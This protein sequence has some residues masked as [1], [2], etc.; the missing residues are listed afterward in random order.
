MHRP[1][2]IRFFFL[3]SIALAIAAGLLWFVLEGPESAIPAAFATWIA[4]LPVPYMLACLFSDRAARKAL[5]DA[6]ASSEGDALDLLKDVDIVLLRRRMLL[7]G[8]PHIKELAPEGMT[9]SALLALA[10]SAEQESDHPYARVICST[11]ENRLLRLHRLAARTA[12][13][14]A[15][16]EALLTRQALRVG[17]LDWLEEEGAKLSA[18]LST[19]ADQLSTKGLAVIGVGLGNRVRG[20]IAFEQDFSEDAKTTIAA[21]SH[22]NVKTVLCTS[23]SRRYG[24]AL[25]KAL[26]ITDVKAGATPEDLAR[27]LQLLKARGSVIATL[28]EDF[29]SI[30]DLTIT[31]APQGVFPPAASSADENAQ[32]PAEPARL[33]L[34]SL[35]PIPTLIA[36]TQRATRALRLGFRLSLFF[37][38]V[39]VLPAFGV[40]HA[41]GGPFFNP[42]IALIG[43]LLATIITNALVL[44]RT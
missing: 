6:H 16:V 31:I 23:G 24:T 42:V 11:A 10:A 14:H 41:V 8:E 22:A 1:I 4:S 3:F 15:G 29:A 19:R 33:L 26:G 34:A 17:R 5:A 18:E 44:S 20:L 21:L 28:S 7:T 36:T 32:A 2:P 35:P 12:V 39:L 37:F 25:A 9:Q 13:P 40:L 38:I 30:A 43:L 27:E